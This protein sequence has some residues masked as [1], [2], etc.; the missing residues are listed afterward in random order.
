MYVAVSFIK[1]FEKQA[2][3]LEQ[4]I[5]EKLDRG[6]IFSERLKKMAE[7]VYVVG[8]GSGRGYLLLA[9]LPW[10]PLGGATNMETKCFYFLGFSA[11]QYF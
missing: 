3:S 1:C 8:R 6:N 5:F 10:A 7:M 9:V 2:H 4:T 11:R